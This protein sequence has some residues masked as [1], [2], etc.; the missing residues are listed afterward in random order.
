MPQM[1]LGMLA[2]YLGAAHPEALIFLLDN[3]ALLQQ[4]RKARPTGAG[5][6]FVRGAKKRF[7]GNDIDVNPFFFII[8][9]RVIKGLFRGGVAGHLVLQC[10]QFSLELFG[11]WDS[12]QRPGIFFGVATGIVGPGFLQ[13]R[14]PP[15]APLILIIILG[16]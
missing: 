14:L 2:A 1:R 13:K 12:A 15:P 7:A 11:G 4:T 8:P 16:L 3:I 10:R 9:I 5:I 6:I